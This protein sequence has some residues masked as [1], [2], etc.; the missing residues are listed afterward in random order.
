MIDIAL[1]KVILADQY[2]MFILD[3][4]SG[5]VSLNGGNA[6]TARSLNIRGLNEKQVAKKIEQS[7]EQKM[8]A[9][10]EH[11]TDDILRCAII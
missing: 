4:M 6:I 2:E 7:S 8:F 5:P 1:L 10:Y 11:S 9:F 3:D